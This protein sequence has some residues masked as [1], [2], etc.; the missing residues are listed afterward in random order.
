M[1]GLWIVGGAMKEGKGDNVATY[2]ENFSEEVGGVN[3]AGEEYNKAEKSLAQHPLLQ[4]VETHVDRLELLR[5]NRGSRR[6][7]RTFVVDKRKGRELLG[8][9]RL[10]RVSERELSQHL[11]TTTTKSR[12]ILCLCHRRNHHRYALAE[13]VKGRIVGS[14][15]GGVGGKS[16]IG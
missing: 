10:V 7:N 12:G 4:P 16:V 15:G 9:S 6:T 3:E 5:A 11:P 2:R 14:G 13:G 1:W 8:W